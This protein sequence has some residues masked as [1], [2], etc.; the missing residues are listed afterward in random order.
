MPIASLESL[1]GRRQFLPYLQA[2]AVD[3]AIIDILWNGCY[4]AMKMASLCEA[5][6][7]N[8]AAHNF[9]AHLGTA[10]SAHCLATVPNFRVLEYQPE[11]VPWRDELFTSVPK[12]VDGELDVAAL[13]ARP[14]WGIDVD[15][16]GVA[17]H[18]SRRPEWHDGGSATRTKL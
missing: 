16:E 15:E 18:P 1:Y 10:I 7:V 13:G 12:I 6:S 4:E 3:V 8:V 9:G 17:R 11:D 5:F 14:G 2:G